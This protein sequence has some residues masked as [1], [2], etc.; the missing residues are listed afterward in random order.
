MRCYLGTLGR[1]IAEV[2]S[3]NQGGGVQNTAFTKKELSE[4]S[5]Q[6]N[7]IPELYDHLLEVLYNYTVQ[8]SHIYITC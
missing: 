5:S 7:A 4:T 1:F 8:P 3:Q 6:V 2:Q